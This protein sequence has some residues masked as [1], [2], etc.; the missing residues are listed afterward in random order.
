M[1]FHP[2]MGLPVDSLPTRPRPISDGLSISVV[3]G[4]RILSLATSRRTVAY[5]ASTE[6][7]GSFFKMSRLIGSNLSSMAINS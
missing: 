6:G 2:T 7:R 1:S 4:F 5:A 3:P